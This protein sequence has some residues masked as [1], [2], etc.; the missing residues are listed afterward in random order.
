MDQSAV[1]T[2]S[3]AHKTTYAPE[4]ADD[5]NQIPAK[6]TDVQA[7]IV[8]NRTKV[9]AD[10][11][12]AAPGLKCVGRLGVGLDNIDLDACAARGIKV[13]PAT[14]ANNLSVAEYVITSAMVLLRNAYQAKHDMLAG[15]WPRM[16][17]AGRE[18]SGKTLGLIGYGANS[19]ETAGLAVA[20]GMEVCAFDPFLPA[21]DL[22]WGE[23]H[24]LSLDGVLETADVVSLHVPLTDETRHLID[25]RRLGQMKSGAVLINAARGGVVDEEAMADAM[26]AGALAGAALDVFESEPLTALDAE[27]FRDLDN[28]QLTPH[29]AGV[30]DESNVRVSSMIAECVLAEL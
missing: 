19:R 13:V 28:L 8:R 25:T 5:Q 26:K 9:T 4:L 29:I 23:T 15:N 14:G 30:T 1:D 20:M 6:M 24:C 11:L 3:A 21:E 16:A 7:F 10:L 27:K 12:D 18:L 17:C 2:L 22:A